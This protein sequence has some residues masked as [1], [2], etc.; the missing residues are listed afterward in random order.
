MSDAKQDDPLIRL[1]YGPRLQSGELAEAFT[2]RPNKASCVRVLVL[3]RPVNGRWDPRDWCRFANRSTSPSQAPRL[4]R[5]QGLPSGR[6]RR[7]G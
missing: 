5:R 2:E 1:R 4:C 6:I 3:R 7:Q